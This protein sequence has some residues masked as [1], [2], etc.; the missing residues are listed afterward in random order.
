MTPK[1]GGQKGHFESP[2]GRWRKQ[3]TGSGDSVDFFGGDSFFGGCWQLY[4]FFGGG[5]HEQ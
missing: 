2:C 4:V 1:I 3:R 5:G